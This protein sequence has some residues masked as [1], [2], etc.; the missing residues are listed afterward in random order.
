MHNFLDLMFRNVAFASPAGSTHFALSAT[1]LDD[2]DVSQADFTEVSGTGY[3]RQLV[4]VNGGTSPTWTAVAAGAASNADLIDFGTVG[5]GGWTMIVS[6]LLIDSLSGAGNI[7]AWN[8]IDVAD[9]TPAEN[10]QVQV[11]VGQLSMSIT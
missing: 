2:Q 11:Q 3:A 10:D 7:L 1:N 5:A 6:G 9:Q 8:N 4:D